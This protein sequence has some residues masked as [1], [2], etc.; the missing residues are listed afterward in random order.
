MF[1]SLSPSLEMWTG[2]DQTK[3]DDGKGFPFFVW[4]LDNKNVIAWLRK[5]FKPDYNDF[6]KIQLWK[7]KEEN[8]MAIKFFFYN[9]FTFSHQLFSSQAKCRKLWTTWIFDWIQE[10]KFVFYLIVEFVCR[11]GFL[12][13]IEKPKLTASSSPLSRHQ[14]LV[15]LSLYQIIF[16]NI[17]H[18]MI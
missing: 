3:F 5:N 1:L 8:D 9:H 16:L 12:S 18:F 15:R 13:W 11:W 2:W 10:W 4:P 17:F 6:K 14:I 7:E